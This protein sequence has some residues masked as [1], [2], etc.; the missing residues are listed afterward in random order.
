[1]V[2][3]LIGIQDNKVDLKKIG[4]ESKDQ[5]VDSFS[6]LLLFFSCLCLCWFLYDIFVLVYRKLFCHQSKT[7]S[8]SLI[9]MRISG[10]LE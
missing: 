4:K 3:E 5:Q 8:L 6:L 9:C 7:H 10:T 2:H 1:M